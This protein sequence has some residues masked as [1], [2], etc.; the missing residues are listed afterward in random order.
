MD[1]RHGI[2]ESDQELADAGSRNGRFLIAVNNPSL[3]LPRARADVPHDVVWRPI[4]DAVAEDNGITA[5]RLSRR[6][7]WIQNGHGLHYFSSV[8]Q[9]HVFVKI[10]ET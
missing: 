7:V 10:F 6:V 9:N 5:A 4:G 8:K 1:R 3:H 2:V